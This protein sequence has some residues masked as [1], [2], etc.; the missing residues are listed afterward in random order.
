MPKVVQTRLDLPVRKTRSGVATPSK[1]LLSPLEDPE[2]KLRTPRRAK[3]DACSTPSVAKTV[4]TPS[5]SPSKRVRSAGDGAD[6]E[7]L[8]QVSPSKQKKLTKKENVGAGG[9][10]GSLLSPSTR[11]SRLA[12]NSPRPGVPIPSPA[13]GTHKSR[14]PLSSKKT[15]E[16]V[17]VRSPAK[18]SSVK[19]GGLFSPQKL[20]G[21]GKNSSPCQVSLSPVAPNHPDK[22]AI[23]AQAKSAK[24]HL[25]SPVKIEPPKPF[26]SPRKAATPIKNVVQGAPNASKLLFSPAKPKTPLPPKSPNPRESLVIT[27]TKALFQP[28]VSHYQ[29]ARQALHTSSPRELLCRESQVKSMSDWLDSHLVD[30]KPG[31]LYVSGA[32]GTGKTA[33]LNYLLE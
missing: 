4:S 11:L 16:N 29:K 27:P 6:L 5:R 26:R 2:K 19:K 21:Q 13:P 18:L 25:C 24:D 14:I 23:R 1:K 7:K 30:G 15:E 10:A 33:T 12:I 32:P 22:V 8:C 31:S 28:D 20:T 9:D 17:A 3:K